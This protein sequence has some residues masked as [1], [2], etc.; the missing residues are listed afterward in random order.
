MV[1]NKAGYRFLMN[2]D[3]VLKNKHP[4]PFSK[5]NPFTIENINVYTRTNKISTECLSKEY[6]GNAVKM[7]WRC[8]CGNEFKRSWANFY[9]GAVLCPDCSNRIKNSISRINY[10]EIITTIGNR[11]YKLIGEVNSLCVWKDRIPVYDEQGY[12]YEISWYDFKDGKN[13]LMFH[14]R[15]PYTIQ[16]I[17]NFFRIELN[18]EFECIS[19]K[20]IDNKSPLNFIHKSCGTI[21]SDPW[22]YVE[23]LTSRFYIKTS[24]S[25]YPSRYRR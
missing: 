2:N 10:D 3:N 13:P 5:E 4:R 24:V 25:S 22:S 21:F 23:R 8:E 18:D 17:N 16:N 6:S 14:H 9:A 7:S 15:N 20:Y 12:Y 11:G 1:E 19:E